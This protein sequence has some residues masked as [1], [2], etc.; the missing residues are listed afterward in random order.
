MDHAI[1]I[2]VVVSS[3]LVAAHLALAQVAYAQEGGDYDKLVLRALSA[4]EAG[5]WDEA[6]RLFEQAHGL[7]PTARTLRTI[8]MAAFNQGDHV[9]ALQNLEAALVD[10][11]KPLTDEQRAHVSALIERA[12]QQ[13]GRFRLRLEPESARLL[14]DGKSPARSRDGELVLMPGRHELEL[15]AAAHVGLT[16]RLDVAARDRGELELA[17]EP[18]RTSSSGLGA[19]HGEVAAPAGLSPAAAASVEGGSSSATWAV[20]ALSVGGAAL[21]TA[22]VTAGLAIS[23][24][25]ELDGACPQRQCS[26]PT[27]DQ[28]DRYDTLR[29]TSAIALAAG[30]VSAGIGTYLLL[31]A[32]G[33]ESGAQVE[34]VVSPRW[35]GVRG[36]L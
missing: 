24:K 21:V 34:A 6:R 25:K 12:N 3:L 19:D 17:L 26:P 11:R 13:V 10:P 28:V 20:V 14:V 31:G 15:S 5:R 29:V 32:D 18:E 23:D 30:V 16:R 36:R 2:G 7:D 1:R 27:Y 33:D 9:A 8:G 22:A 4:Y 35:L